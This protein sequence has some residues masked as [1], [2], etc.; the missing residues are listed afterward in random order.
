MEPKRPTRFF[1]AGS[2]AM[3]SSREMDGVETE[4]ANGVVEVMLDAPR[5]GAEF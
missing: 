1:G 2:F 5:N 4:Y 3:S